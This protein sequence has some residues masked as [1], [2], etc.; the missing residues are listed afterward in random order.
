MI[1]TIVGADGTGKSTQVRRLHA[2]LRQSGAA[3]SLIDKWDVL[4]A[5]QNTECRFIQSDRLDIAR[6]IAEMPDDARAFFLFWMMGI[7]LKSVSDA[8]DPRTIHLIDGYWQKH[9]VSE[10]VLGSPTEWVMGLVS[11]FPQS[12]LVIFLD[13]PVDV[14]A[15]R[16]DGDYSLYE[17]G[18]DP[19]RSVAAFRRHQSGIRARLQA[20]AADEGWHRIDASRSADAVERDIRAVVDDTLRGRA[21]TP[22]SA[23]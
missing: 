18:L 23:D 1:I 17:C 15:V 4:D 5:D 21:A 16:K 6:C 10:M 20:M 3:V 9:A 12:D 22:S 13:A 8:P 14:S 11:I 19:S 2:Y 7:G